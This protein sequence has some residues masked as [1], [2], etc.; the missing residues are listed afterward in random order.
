MAEKLTKADVQEIFAI[1]D[2]SDFDELHIETEGLKL[3]ARRKGA[4]PAQA[5]A[6]SQMAVAVAT[7]KMQAGQTEAAIAAPASLASGDII[8]VPAPMLGIFYSAPK[9]G[10]EPFV[11]PGMKIGPETVVGIIEV[12]K[13]MNPVTSGL[14]GIAVEIAVTDGTMVEFGQTILRI[15]SE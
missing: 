8:N 13:L 1:L 10:A 14:S 15:R 4:A 6:D 7:P 11:T 3:T 12:M 5:P 2:S 9:P